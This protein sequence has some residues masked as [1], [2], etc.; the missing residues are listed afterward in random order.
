MIV[1][2]VFVAGADGLAL[3]RRT[4]D[5]SKSRLFHQYYS[6][7]RGFAETPTIYHASGGNRTTLRLVAYGKLVYLQ[8]CL[9]CMAYLLKRKAK[10]H[11]KNI[12]QALK[13]ECKHRRR[14]RV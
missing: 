6:S 12:R 13:R 1:L 14:F 2:A 8:K 4:Q 10:H 11:E 5:F 9:N 7:T 3:Y